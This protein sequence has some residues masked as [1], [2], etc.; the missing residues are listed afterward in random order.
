MTINKLGAFA[1]LLSG[2]RIL[3]GLERAV[4]REEPLEE[5]LGD[6]GVVVSERLKGKGSCDGKRDFFLK[7]DDTFSEMEE[8][9]G[10]S[11][12]KHSTTLLLKSSIKSIN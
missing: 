5:D 10:S 1:R 8:N 3:I 12:Y 11:S 6:G 7:S 2:S 4:C 9:F